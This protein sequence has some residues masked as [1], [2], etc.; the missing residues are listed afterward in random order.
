[1]VHLLSARVGIPPELLISGNLPGVE[2]PTGF[3]MRNQMRVAEP[4]L[5]GCYGCGF[6]RDLIG[7]DVALGKSPIQRPLALD[8][9][10]AKPF[11]GIS[12]EFFGAD[13]R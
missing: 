10:S 7:R 12:P 9:I 4:S 11:C 6:G 1:M 3:D 5:W 13:R 2:H 8:K